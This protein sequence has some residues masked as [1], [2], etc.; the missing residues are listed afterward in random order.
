MMTKF[1]TLLA[2]VFLSCAQAKPSTW[3]NIEDYGAECGKESTAAIQAA[4]TAGEGKTV[5]VPPCGS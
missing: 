4:L 2:I 3:V 1:G 5:F